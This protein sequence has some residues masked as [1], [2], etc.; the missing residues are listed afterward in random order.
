MDENKTV[1]ASDFISKKQN[2]EEKEKSIWES[3]LDT[4]I[5]CVF[6]VYHW[7]EY[8]ESAAVSLF[9]ILCIAFS[10][11]F[12]CLTVYGKILLIY[13]NIYLHNPAVQR[14]KKNYDTFEG[15]LGLLS[16]KD[17]ERLLEIDF[18]KIGGFSVLY[19]YMYLKNLKDG[20]EL[21]NEAFRRKGLNNE[22]RYLE[23]DKKVLLGCLLSEGQ[24]DP[25]ATGFVPMFFQKNERRLN[26]NLTYYGL[27]DEMK[28]KYQ[29]PISP[30]ALLKTY[31]KN[32]RRLKQAG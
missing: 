3:G 15:Y 17:Q 32:Q 16:E 2:P 23:F 14:R 4:M 11:A 21:L 1:K 8:P 26:Y 19:A 18:E 6:F 25:E 20:L 12:L 10:I 22:H 9:F 24:K 30:E 28:W 7:E 31:G 29:K 27:V 13:E 5:E